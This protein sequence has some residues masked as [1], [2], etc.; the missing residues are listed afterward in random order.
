MTTAMM[1]KG[2]VWKDD[3]MM[4]KQRLV[5]RFTSD[6]FGE[7][8]SISDDKSVMLQIDFK[9][10]EELVKAGRKLGGKDE[11]KQKISDR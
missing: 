5:V 8:F 1:A 7:T 10:V 2:I 6:E 4:K 3:K 9:G 11:R